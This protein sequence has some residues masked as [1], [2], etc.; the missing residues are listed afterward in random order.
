MKISTQP[1]KGTRDFYPNDKKIQ[2]YIFKI[3]SDIAQ[4]FGYEEYAA[5]IVESL[6][7]Y[8]AKT[9]EE[10]VNDQTYVFED[11]GGRKVTLRPE[12]TPS[13]SRMVAARRQELAYPLRWYSIS[14]IWRYERPQKGRMR[15]HWQLNVD[16]FGVAGIEAD[17]ELVLIADT[18]MQRF[19]AKRDTYVIRLNNRQIVNYILNEHLK[20]NEDS[21][22][23]VIRLVD[24]MQKMPKDSF[25]EALEEIVGDKIRELLKILSVDSVNGLPEDIQQHESAKKLHQLEMMLVRCGVT[26]A[27]FDITLMRGFDYYT[28]IV[29]E[30]FDTN[31]EN[32]RSLFGSGRYDALVGM[33][34][35][36][37]IPTVGFAVG[38]V[39]MIEF[40]KLHQLIPSFGIK[41]DIDVILI[42]DVYLQAQE[43][44]KEL[45][46]AGLNIAVDSSNNKIDKQL[47]NAVKA[48]YKYVLFIGEKEI[49]D[50]KF[51]LK[52]ISTSKEQRIT[53]EEIVGTILKQ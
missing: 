17:H 21:S 28:D 39:T 9:S 48:G 51:N 31:P 33:F 44:L 4:S 7:I 23:K 13:V 20:L 6:D 49:Q 30:L 15:E 14:N 40:L 24:R 25:N 52:E 1:Y 12:M 29:F 43:L 50:K 34:G 26:N 36:E 8:L 46:D 2:N 19:G 5:P 47:K 42:G 22:E 35:V 10:I 37:P 32:S 11:R 3:W 41:P 18:I 45:R 27:Q 16:L 53:I 38:D